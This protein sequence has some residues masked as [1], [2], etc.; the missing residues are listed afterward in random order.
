MVETGGGQR[1]QTVPKAKDDITLSEEET[2]VMRNLI[3]G[4]HITEEEYKKQLKFIKS[5]N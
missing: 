3:R 2:G 4:G 5:R 1:K